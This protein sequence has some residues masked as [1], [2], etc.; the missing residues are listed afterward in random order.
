MER[1]DHFHLPARE[2]DAFLVSCLVEDE[3]ES[4][5]LAE[6]RGYWLCDDA[7]MR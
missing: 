2:H 6:K 5:R 4:Y 7:E 3:P 1:D